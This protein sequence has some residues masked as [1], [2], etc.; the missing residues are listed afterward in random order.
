MTVNMLP[1]WVALGYLMLSGPVAILTLFVV[2]KILAR[3]PDPAIRVGILIGCLLYIACVPW[4]YVVFALP[5][6]PCSILGIGP[7]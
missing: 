1:N 3:K 2:P 7:C 6:Q 4:V 5:F